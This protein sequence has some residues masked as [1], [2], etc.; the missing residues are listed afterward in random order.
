MELLSPLKRKDVDMTRLAK[1][2]CGGTKAGSVHYETTPGSRNIVAWRIHTA[3]KDGRCSIRV[4]DSPRESD[5]QLVLPTDGSAS[6]DG[7]FPCGRDVTPYE[8]KEFKIPKTLECDSCILQL[9]W[10]TEAGD[11]Y[12]CV[13]FES[14]SGEVPECFGQ[15]LNGGI[16]RNGACVCDDGFSG[17][18]C[19]FVVETETSDKGDSLTQ[20]LMDNSVVVI[21]YG[22]MIALI[23]GL[24]IGA[25]MMFSAAR[26][27]SDQRR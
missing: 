3:A 23:V 1:R 21:F 13:D 10:H 5:Y 16:C 8:A 9:I 18:N 4:S 6:D 11:Q 27:R 12:R 2:P 26:R 7:T 14:V 22:L 24:F 20:A 17:S 15:C 19:Q 25:W